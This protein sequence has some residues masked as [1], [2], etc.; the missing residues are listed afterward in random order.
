MIHKQ[1]SITVQHEINTDDY[2]ALSR[3][4]ELGHISIF[5]RVLWVPNTLVALDNTL[6]T[7]KYD[8]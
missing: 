3:G 7:N 1:E 2:N 6:H 5:N 8:Y 4:K